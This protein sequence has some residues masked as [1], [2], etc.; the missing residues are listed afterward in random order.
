MRTRNCD[1]FDIK[2]LR[3]V[4]GIEIMLDGV[5][6]RLAENG[7]PCLFKTKEARYL[8]REEYRRKSESELLSE[9]RLRNQP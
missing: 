7:E 8:K 9:I 2:S 3:T 4:Y 5:W 6:L 1:Y